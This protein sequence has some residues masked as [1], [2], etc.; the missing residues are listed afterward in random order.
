MSF[1]Q[2][3]D[4]VDPGIY[5]SSFALLFLSRGRA[6]VLFNKLEYN[7]ASS[8]KKPVEGNWNQRPRDIANL[9]HFIGRERE[10]SMNW[11]IVNLQQAVDH[12]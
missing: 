6:P 8:S 10:I 4:A 9:T 1:G 11:Q 7:L 5:D 2:G 3:T 12:V